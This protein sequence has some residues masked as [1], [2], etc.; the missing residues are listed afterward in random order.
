MLKTTSLARVHRRLRVVPRRRDPLLADVQAGRVLPGRRVLVPRADDVWSAHPGADRAQAWRRATRGEELTFASGCGGAGRRSG[1]GRAGR[2]D[3]PRD[4]ESSCAPRTCTSASGASRCSRASTSRCG[5]ARRSA[6]S[7][8]PGSGKT[9]F[10]RCIN[11]LEKIDGG[12]IEVNGHLIGYRE[13]NGKLVEDSERIDRAAARG[14]RDGLPALQPL[15]AHDGAR[16]RDR[17]AG[18]RPGH[19]RGSVAVARGGGAARRASG[20]RTSAT[21]TRASSPAA[22]SS[23]SRSPALSR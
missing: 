14:D 3:E 5:A 10:L 23:A 11:H 6:S 9:T 15:P 2:V 18:P 12:R 7:A 20:S 19:R 21:S 13:R 8:R 4:A 22:S 16:E 17:G 1:R